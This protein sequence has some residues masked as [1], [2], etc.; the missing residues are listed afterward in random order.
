MESCQSLQGL[1][2]L[3]GF[4]E[5][6]SHIKNL[7]IFCHCIRNGT[8]IVFEFHNLHYLSLVLLDT[9]IVRNSKKKKRR[10]FGQG[11]PKWDVRSLFQNPQFSQNLGT[12][13]TNMFVVLKTIKISGTLHNK[14]S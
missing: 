1:L 9:E 6:L 8:T 3:L 10:Y 7:Q 11:E 5:N 2:I 4:V 13:L 12:R 14:I